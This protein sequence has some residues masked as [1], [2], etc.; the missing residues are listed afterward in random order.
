MSVSLDPGC[1]AFWADAGAPSLHI[2]TPADA[3]HLPRSSLDVSRLRQRS[4]LVDGN[5]TL[6]SRSEASPGV[7]LPLGTGAL[8]TRDATDSSL[9]LATPSF[10]SM[11]AQSS[12]PPL[13]KASSTFLLDSRS[14]LPGSSLL[15]DTPS[16]VGLKHVASTATGEALTH[17]PIHPRLPERTRREPK[18]LESCPSSATNRSVTVQRL[19]LDLPLNGSG[20][21]SVL[22]HALED[23]APG[24]YQSLM[25]SA[26]PLNR[27]PG[28]PPT[29]SAHSPPSSP[30]LQNNDVIHILPYYGLPDDMLASLDALEAIASQ[31][32]LLPSPQAK[33][34]VVEDIDLEEDVLGVWKVEES[35]TKPPETQLVSPPLTPT[36]DDQGRETTFPRPPSSP[37]QRARESTDSLW[38]PETPR[39][40]SVASMHVPAD[41]I[42]SAST[43]TRVAV[44]NIANHPKLTRTLGLSSM[45]PSRL[46]TPSTPRR[47]VGAI[48]TQPL[49]PPPHPIPS[50]EDS[51][52]LALSKKASSRSLKGSRTPKALKSIFRPRASAPPVPPLHSFAPEHDDPGWAESDGSPV[53]KPPLYNRFSEAGMRREPPGA[54]RRHFSSDHAP[55]GHG[56]IHGHGS[57]LR[58]HLHHLPHLHHAGPPAVDVEA[59]SFLV[60]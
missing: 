27:E 29:N 51:A 60:L 54:V 40:P 1:T 15:S 13:S 58:H 59:D 52:P 3:T 22:L 36:E 37:H 2:E 31:V 38:D 10:L 8:A 23:A 14:L 55:S 18:S 6:H 28:S 25:D 56:F 4:Y 32:Q 21:L 19:A 12:S 48:P 42:E 47:R 46:P 9:L 44:S 39:P 41:P 53:R 11:Q 45:S 20:S 5:A 33:P 43:S 7:S 50:L 24:W 34:R 26:A 17:I 35:V 16:F 49:P 57:G 30:R